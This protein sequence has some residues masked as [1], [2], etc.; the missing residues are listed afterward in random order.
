[1]PPQEVPTHEKVTDIL[2]EMLESMKG[3]DTYPDALQIKD[4]RQRY[5]EF[6]RGGRFPSFPTVTVAENKRKK[7]LKVA[8]NPNSSEVVTLGSMVTPAS[9]VSPVSKRGVDSLELM[10]GGAPPQKKEPPYQ[11]A[12]MLTCSAYSLAVSIVTCII[13]DMYL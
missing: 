8:G 13:V 1:M 7:S 4:G 11:I 9:L 2:K 6:L 3:H 12:L 5:E 10:D